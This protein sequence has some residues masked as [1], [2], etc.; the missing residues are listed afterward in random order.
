MTIL[1]VRHLSRGF[2]GLVA[3]SDL[4]F[5]VGEGEIRGLIGP[6][7]AGKTTTFNVISGFYPPSA[8]RVLF[9][10]EDVSGLRTSAIAAR[11][12]VRTFQATTLFQELTV[13]ENVLVGCHLQARTNPFRAMFGAGRRRE[14]AVR[15]KAIEILDFFGLGER[16]DDL[17]GSLPHGLQRALGV[18]VA[19]A[20]DPVLL[21]LDEPFT[22]MNPEETRRMMETVRKVRDRGVTLLLV[23]HDMQA[24]MGLCDRITVLNFGRLLTEGTPREVRR[25]PGVIEAYLGAEESAA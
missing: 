24:V 9:R 3:V 23:E 7:G 19:F 5:S 10:G 25:H 11:G 14:A 22:G 21:L 17:A 18:A 16:G 2:G 20:A 4:S 12:L 1:E 8:G 15:D 6:N 13:L